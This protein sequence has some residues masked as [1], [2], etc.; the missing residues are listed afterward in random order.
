MKRVLFF[1]LICL[2]SL[3][4]FHGSD[5]KDNPL[6]LT[7]DNVRK[8]EKFIEPFK[9][10]AL[11][12]YPDAKRKFTAGLEKGYIFYVTTMIYEGDKKEQVFLRV[13]KIEDNKIYSVIASEINLLTGYK[14]NDDYICNEEDIVDWSILSPDGKEEGNFVGKMLE[15]YQNPPVGLIMKLIYNRKG[16]LTDV[17]FMYALSTTK[18][19]VTFSLPESVI[20]EGIHIAKGKF[21]KSFKNRNKTVYGYVVYHYLNKEFIDN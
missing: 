16:V 13:E 17:S 4:V 5:S 20:Q 10:L 8:V 11:E 14:I 18:Y 19:D 21:K 1:I 6:S 2:V 3:H 7:A 12:T 15:V 9:K